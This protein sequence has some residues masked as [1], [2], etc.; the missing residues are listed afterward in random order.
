MDTGT[1]FE[2]NRTQ[3]VTLPANTHFPEGIKIVNVCVVG[4]DRV[5]SPVENTWDSFFMSTDSVSNDFMHER[6]CQK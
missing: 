4:V 5:L 1:I 3:M 2:K 6:A